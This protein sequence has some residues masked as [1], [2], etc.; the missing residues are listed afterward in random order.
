[1]DAGSV[2][3]FGDMQSIMEQCG[4]RNE[5]SMITLLLSPEMG[6]MGGP[7]DFLKS[8]HG[9]CYYTQI[10]TLVVASRLPMERSK[11]PDEIITGVM[12]GA[13]QRISSAV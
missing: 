3:N 2:L 4:L 9:F 5:M 6:P 13:L 12:T 10:T 1:M 7:G 8:N 11:G